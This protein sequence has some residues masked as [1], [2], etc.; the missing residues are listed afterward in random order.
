MAKRKSA[1]AQTTRSRY[2]AR[3]Y[4]GLQGKVVAYISKPPKTAAIAVDV[5]PLIH[6][7][8]PLSVIPAFHR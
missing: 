4:P 2:T 5:P 8:D 3:R 6:S 1:A 7:G